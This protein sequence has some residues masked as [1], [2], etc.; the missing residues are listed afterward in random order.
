MAEKIRELGIPVSDDQFVNSASALISGLRHER[1][2][3]KVFVVGEK[4]FIDGL[5]ASGVNVVA[6]PKQADTVVSAMDRYFTYEKLSKAHEAI[7][8][9]AV[10]W[11]TNTDATYPVEDGFLPGSG[12]IV[13]A[14]AAA[15]GRPP[16]RIFGK[17]STDMADLALDV[18]GLQREECL[19]VGD[20]METDIL[21]ARNAGIASALVLTGATSREDL[22]D[23]QYAPDYIIESIADLDGVITTQ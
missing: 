4:P 14:I 10:Y 15:A 21:F 9:G 12:S 19:I 7:A 20:R 13:A 22:P 2:S 8:R 6:D 23:Y 1:P 18:L 11:V 5:I 16:D 3:A 17:P